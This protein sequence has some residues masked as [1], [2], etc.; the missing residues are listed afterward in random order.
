MGFFD[1][2]STTTSNYTDAGDY[3][4]QAAQQDQFLSEGGNITVNSLDAGSVNNALAF[5]NNAIERISGAFD[6][7]IKTQETSYSQALNYSAGVVGE[8]VNIAGQVATGGN[9]TTNA[10]QKNLMIGAAFLAAA[11]VLYKVIK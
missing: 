3:R 11:F 9:F 8:G 10:M 7:L 5:A 4:N 2:D 1:S 6:S